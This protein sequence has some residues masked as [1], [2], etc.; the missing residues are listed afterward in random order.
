MVNDKFVPQSL[1]TTQTAER[2][3]ANREGSAFPG[4]LDVFSPLK[5]ISYA[6]H[7]TLDTVD[8]AVPSF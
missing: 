6:D 4:E 3:L 7:L 1:E 2:I 8:Q 5:Y